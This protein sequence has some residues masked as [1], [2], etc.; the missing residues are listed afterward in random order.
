MKSDLTSS[1]STV[2]EQESLLDSALMLVKAEAF[3]MKR[4][5]DRTEIMEGLKHAVQMLSELRTSALTPKFYY[6]LC[7]V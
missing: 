4:S 3:E 2:I 5:L 1:D 7:K 6:R